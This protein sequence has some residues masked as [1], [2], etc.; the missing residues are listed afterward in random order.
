MSI[1]ISRQNDI[2][3]D[4]YNRVVYD[5]ETI[6]FAHDLLTSIDKSHSDFID[7]LKSG[8]TVYG[9]TT[10]SGAMVNDPVSQS[11]WPERQ[12]NALV[13]HSAAIGKPLPYFVSRGILFLRIN[14][15]LSGHAAASVNLVNYMTNRLNEG[16]TPWVPSSGHGMDGETIPHTHM[17]Q[18]L[19]GEGFLI[20][21]DG[22]KV[23]AKTYL[24][25]NSLSPFEP[26]R[27]DGGAMINGY[28]ASV[29]YAVHARRH[30]T[31][32]LN[33]LTLVAAISIEG[34]AAS[35]EHYSTEISE[36]QKCLGLS[37]INNTIRLYLE[38]S[39]VDRNT[40]QAP[41]SYR[42]TPQLH[43]VLLETLWRIDEEVLRN[44]SSVSNNAAFFPGGDSE[45][46]YVIHGGQFHN[47]LLVNI[48]D[49][50]ALAIAQ[51][52]LLSSKRLHRLMD[53]SETN[54]GKQLSLRPGLDSG[55]I[56][57]H[58]AAIGFIPQL[59]TMANPYSL[60]TEESSLGHTDVETMA[61]PA[62]NRLF[63]MSDLVRM[64]SAYELYAALVCIDQRGQKV[65]ERIHNIRQLVRQSIPPYT[66]DRSYGPEIELLIELFETPDFKNKI[67]D[68]ETPG[69]F[70]V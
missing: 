50:A 13:N 37:E 64:M 51:V 3:L 70:T 9:S 69:E 66:R 27:R 28:G 58:K 19:I 48:V 18:T 62:I 60:H 15:L 34:I 68:V 5:G 22:N 55:L 53:P 7:F 61:L 45:H 46:A 49:G 12:Y 54:L 39:A 30:L 38:G 63:A 35:A 20:T 47:Q 67:I 16:F 32:L 14:A 56:I 44:M 8:S 41:I 6:E 24:E 26:S 4:V 33:H 10:G 11:D 52:G 25:E 1:Y 36:L 40:L 29:A 57:L 43:A 17:A 2:T 42:V 65:S 31:C 21:P 23:S 59:K